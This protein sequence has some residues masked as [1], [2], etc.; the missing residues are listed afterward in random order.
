MAF[1]A[2]LFILEIFTGPSIFIDRC[3]PYLKEVATYLEQFTI[4]K[5]GIR[6]LPLSSSPEFKDNSMDAW[7]R[8]MTNFDRALVRF[9]FRAA[10]ELARE[11]G[12]KDELIIGRNWRKNYLILFLMLKGDCLLL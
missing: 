2:F 11:L 5:D 3:Y 1:P 7:F 10:A 4:V 9:A 12:R 8:E 6:S